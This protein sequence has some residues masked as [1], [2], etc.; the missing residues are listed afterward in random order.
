MSGRLELLPSAGGGLSLSFSGLGRIGQGGLGRVGAGPCLGA[1]AQFPEQR[2]E[3]GPGVEQRGSLSPDV[4]LFLQEVSHQARWGAQ[5]RGPFP[6]SP[7]LRGTGEVQPWNRPAECRGGGGG[8][9]AV[10]GG[11]EQACCLGGA[12]TCPPAPLPLP[13]AGLHAYPSSRKTRLSP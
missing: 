11:P 9:A 1:A 6:L 3:V 10:L 12:H 2:G 4:A 13:V 5:S 7:S 8:A